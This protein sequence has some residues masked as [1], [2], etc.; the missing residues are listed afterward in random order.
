M[1]NMAHSQAK[2][3]RVGLVILVLQHDDDDDDG[4]ARSGMLWTCVRVSV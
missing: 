4:D 2:C 1:K 3:I